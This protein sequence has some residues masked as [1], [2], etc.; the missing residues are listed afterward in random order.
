MLCVTSVN[1]HMDSFFLQSLVCPCVSY[2]VG[3]GHSS[4]MFLAYLRLGLHCFS[5]EE[6]WVGSVARVGELFSV[7][8]CTVYGVED[9]ILGMQSV[10]PCLDLP[11]THIYLHTAT[12]TITHVH[13][14]YTYTFTYMLICY[15]PIHV[16]YYTGV[17]RQ[18]FTVYTWK[19]VDGISWL[20]V[21]LADLWWVRKEGLLRQALH[22]TFGL[23]DYSATC[24]TARISGLFRHI[25]SAC[26]AS[27]VCQR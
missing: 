10:A 25:S 15:T 19:G 18:A 24:G 14:V 26:R 13:T 2:N 3:I 20:V 9:T 27:A 6:E 8:S 16:P 5:L 21:Q 17:R 4:E 22:C 12:Y 23:W 11:R 7:F 1:V